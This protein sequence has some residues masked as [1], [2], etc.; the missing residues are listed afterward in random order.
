MSF[1]ALLALVSD[2]AHNFLDVLDQLIRWI[3]LV[4]HLLLS[5]NV[6]DLL[7]DGAELECDANC[8]GDCVRIVNTHA[9]QVRN[10]V[11]P[12]PILVIDVTL[13]LVDE[14]DYAIGVRLVLPIHGTNHEVVHISH[15]WLIVHCTV[16]VGLLLCI[17]ADEQLSRG[18]DMTGQ[19]IRCLETNE[20]LLLFPVQVLHSLCLAERLIVFIVLILLLGGGNFREQWI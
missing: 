13:L 8:L 6:V 10:L 5:H 18:E 9:N 20:L 3:L 4:H 14:L 16:E 1:N 19:S 7:H 11:K 17:I 2:G 12:L 15:L